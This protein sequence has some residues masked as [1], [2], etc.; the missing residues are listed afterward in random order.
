MPSTRRHHFVPI[1]S[2]LA[3]NCATGS[4]IADDTEIDDD[5]TS[6][7][8]TTSLMGETGTL[9]ITENGSITVS[10]GPALTLTGNHSLLMQGTIQ[11][12]HE[13]SAL[14]LGVY[15]D[16]LRLTSNINIEGDF[17][18]AGP[19]DID[20]GSTNVALGIFGNGIFEGDLT[21]SDTSTIVVNGGS[22]KGI[23]IGSEFIG[24]LFSEAVIS[25][26]GD[27]G[28]GVDLAGVITGDA[29]I[30][31]TITARDA[32]SYGIRQTGKVD[33]ALIHQ[34]SIFVGESAYYDDDSNYIDAEPASAGIYVANDISG[35]LMLGGEGADYEADDDATDA[36]PS[37]TIYSYGG[38]P[39]LLIENAKTDGAD[40][41]L[42]AVSGLDYGLM[43]RGYM[44]VTGQ[45]SGLNAIG[46]DIRGG[47]NGAGTLIE[48]GIHI[49]DGYIDVGALDAEATGIRLGPDVSM[50]EIWNRGVIRA[51]TSA[52]YDED[53]ETYSVGGDAFGILIEEGSS[54][55][56]FNNEGSLVASAAGAGGNSF[57]LR[58]LSGT[59]TTVSNS[60]TWYVARGS[61][62]S[63]D[64]IAL[65]AS[66]S[67]AD[68]SFTNEGTVIG[69]VLLGSGSDSVL[70]ADGTF[71]GDIDFGAGSNSFTLRGEAEFTGDLVHRGS[72]D[73]YLEGA[74]L[75][76]ASDDIFEV[77][78]ASFTDGATL[79]I[80]VDPTDGEAG[81]IATTGAM[82]VADDVTITTLFDTILTEEQ[83]YKVVDTGELNFEGELVTGN[84]AF[85]VH[86][87]LT[88]SDDGNDIYL[89]V[90]PKTADELSF[91]GNRAILYDNIF[92]FLDP[93]DD[94]AKALAQLD[95][96]ED[97][98]N[99]IQAMMPDTTASSLQMA[100]SASLQLEATMNDRLTEVSSN[101]KLE[102][103]FWAREVLG[104]GKMDGAISGQSVD[105]LG[106]G[107]LLGF[108]KVVSDNLLWGLGTGF[109]LQGSERSSGY[110]DDVSVFSPYVQTYLIARSG[111][112][113][114]STSA[115]LWYNAVE[116]SRALDFGTIDKLVE[117]KMRGFSANFDVHA[118]Y[119]LKV[120]GLHIMPKVGLSYLHVG[121]GGYTETGGDGGNMVL[122]GRSYNRLDGIGRVSV[123]HDFHWSGRGDDTTTIRPEIFAS[124]RK[125]LTGNSVIET[126]ARFENGTEWFSLENDAIADKSY[127]LGAALNIF[128]GFGTAS[129]R[130][131]YENR[132]DWKSHYGGFNFQMR[133]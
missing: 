120:G 89:T 12:D 41:T 113:F 38:A 17:S 30:D 39:A 121:E 83:S 22:S 62:S 25:V 32:G 132:D 50:P 125:N 99:A 80:T 123:G 75:T 55:T 5:R 81:L 122:D 133:F 34:G 24:D 21:L 103:G 85:L 87:S 44:S 119:D 61:N 1:F 112:A 31:G 67:G 127:E 131:A 108:D 10:S 105:Y 78:T 7:V 42:G 69:D 114:A 98:E 71:T 37:S 117:G 82:N 101:K 86:S 23:Y 46:I 88:L 76:L 97:V 36:V 6:S 2:L 51:S 96:A 116:R 14:G 94:L 74:D 124:Y 57:G 70:L 77:T 90:R 126:A 66:T 60:G 4:V 35:G 49:D 33:G 104:V 93:Q 27:N 54:L 8:D 106:A 65:D 13:T 110:G 9:T 18:I 91:S 118:G 79:N 47:Q 111:S 63:G 40:L 115:S 73:F 16:D 68:I 26:G 100:Y 129:L 72:L 43:H 64:V 3:L 109:L 20:T 84:G 29:T 52:T 53:D 130:Y 28:I 45:S 56:T 107:I 48:G 15:T 19:T 92:T 102:G 59:L 95:T 11:N 58:D 128:S